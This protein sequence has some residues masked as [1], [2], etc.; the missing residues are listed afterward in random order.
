MSVDVYDHVRVG[1]D[2]PVP[3]GTY[4]VVGTG[5]TVTLL[6]VADGTGRRE[7]SGAIEHADGETLAEAFEHAE[8]P[9]AGFSLSALLAP[10]T[11]L[12]KAVRHWLGR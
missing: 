12:P 5:E 2:A 8:N 6:R 9:D 11:T 10:F 7:N 3:A 4:R 1:T